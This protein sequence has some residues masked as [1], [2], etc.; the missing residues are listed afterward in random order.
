MQTVQ[1]PLLIS[2][3]VLNRQSYLTDCRIKYGNDKFLHSLHYELLNAFAH[4]IGSRP[5]D[6]RNAFALE[7]GR[8]P[9]NPR[10]ALSGDG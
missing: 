10:E 1:N 3:S 9:K 7:N 2:L 6:A 5:F 8:E 4:L